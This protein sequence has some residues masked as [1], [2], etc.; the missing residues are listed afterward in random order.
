MP[1]HSLTNMIEGDT[2]VN[3]LPLASTP[4]QISLYYDVPDI[5]K[6]HNDVTAAK[7]AKREHRRTKSK[8]KRTRGSTRVKEEPIEPDIHYIQ[9]QRPPRGQIPVKS[10][11]GP[12]DIDA[13]EPAPAKARI[14]V[15]SNLSPS[16]AASTL[17]TPPL[18][19]DG[20]FSDSQAGSTNGSTTSPKTGEGLE[21][22][23]PSPESE[24]MSIDNAPTAQGEE[25]P[26]PSMDVEDP[27]QITVESPGPEQD[28]LPPIDVADLPALPTP[29]ISAQDPLP[30]GFHP[31]QHWDLPPEI[32]GPEYTEAPATVIP[33]ANFWQPIHPSAGHGPIAVGA[34][35][36]IGP[37]RPVMRPTFPMHT[38]EPMHPLMEYATRTSQPQAQ[39]FHHLSCPTSEALNFTAPSAHSNDDPLP[40]LDA[41]PISSWHSL[42]SSSSLSSAMINPPEQQ[43]A[44]PEPSRSQ[45]LLNSPGPSP[46]AGSGRGGPQRREPFTSSPRSTIPPS[47]CH[48]E[49]DAGYQIKEATSSKPKASSPAKSKTKG[50]PAPADADSND[51]KGKKRFACEVKGC[52]ATFTRRNDVERHMKSAAAHRNYA[53]EW[54]DMQKNQAPA[55]N[56]FR[57]E[58][59]H[60]ILS[61]ADSAKRHMESGACGK[62]ELP[63]EQAISGKRDNARR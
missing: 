47:K 18:T 29:T 30:F 37:Q 28:L 3:K 27:P 24:P 5:E 39:P 16:A 25:P 13:M 62:R 33:D 53:Q 21:Q 38:P 10:L 42:L 6:Y 22:Q 20:T 32:Q 7:D 31:A 57:C 12:F 45:P 11:L 60:R 36:S 52:P 58:K 48:D 19:A 26:S 4:V 34:V 51:K 46:S 35:Q 17:P 40:Q 63:S 15:T 55:L 49:P 2:L 61:R 56:A 50:V 43:N 44:A 14:L 8:S 54:A 41:F 23:L 9:L 1:G 59:C